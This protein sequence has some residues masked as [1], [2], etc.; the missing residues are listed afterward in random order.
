MSVILD[1][2]LDE[3]IDRSIDEGNRSGNELRD[4]PRDE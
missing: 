1:I 4:V 2:D 3:L